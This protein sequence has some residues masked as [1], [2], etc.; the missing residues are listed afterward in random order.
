MMRKL[1]AT[2]IGLGLFCL[3]APAL[4]RYSAQVQ[5]VP[6]FKERVKVVALAPMSCPADLDCLWLEAKIAEHLGSYKL[7]KVIAAERVRQTLFEL[8][9]KSVDQIPPASLLEKLGAD[10]LILATVAGAGTKAKGAVGVFTGTSIVMAQEE[11]KH[12]NVEVAFVGADGQILLQGVG[13]G[14]SGNELKS[15]KGVVLTSFKAVF[16]KAFPKS[17][18]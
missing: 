7:F 12:G 4:A 15:E 2:L 5:Q 17:A 13:T 9:V 8:G 11:V 1:A 6:D 18:R 10:A 14:T 3:G 16:E